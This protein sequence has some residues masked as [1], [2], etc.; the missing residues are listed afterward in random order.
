M[1]EAEDSGVSSLDSSASEEDYGD[2]GAAG[3][4]D[5]EV[6]GVEKPAVEPK[7]AHR[8]DFLFFGLRHTT[9]APLSRPG[10]I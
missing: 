2:D 4:S 9:V 1:N 7:N 8:L 5:A 3:A 10:G 6:T